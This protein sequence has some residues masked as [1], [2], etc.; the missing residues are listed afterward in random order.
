MRQE[1]SVKRNPIKQMLGAETEWQPLAR[2][3]HRH[4]HE[5]LLMEEGGSSVYFFMPR[6]SG[7]P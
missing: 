5:Q 2:D 7:G 6:P 4:P 3:M 1:E